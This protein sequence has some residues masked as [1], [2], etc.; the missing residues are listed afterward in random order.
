ME[1]PTTP[2]H[3]DKLRNPRARI[4]DLTLPGAAN[5]EPIRIRQGRRAP[6]LFLFDDAG[7]ERCRTAFAE[8]AARA[9]ELTE[10]DGR[11]VAVLP[12][13]P[14]TEVDR[15]W[16]EGLSVPA[17][18][19]SESRIA[20]AAGVAAPAVV[21]ADQ[22]GEIHEVHAAGDDH[23]PV[24]VDRIIAALRYLSVRCPECEGEAL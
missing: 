15:A 18:V 2:P 10:W 20:D 12:S 22:W 5:G 16:I 3:S 6:V 19:D 8:I 7:C 23:P 1:R 17:V 13:P 11:L 4:P 14:A 9:G 21:V 24:P